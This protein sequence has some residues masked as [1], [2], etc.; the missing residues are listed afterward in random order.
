MESGKG[1]ER[2]KDYNRML[3]ISTSQAPLE[4]VEELVVW[5]DG[6]DCEDL[7]GFE[8][9]GG[10]EGYQTKFTVRSHQNSYT[11]SV[12]IK[13]NG[14]GISDEKKDKIMRL[15]YTTPK[16]TESTGLR[17]TI[18]NDIV[19]AHGSRLSFQETGIT[20]TTFG[21]ELWAS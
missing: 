4:G 19:K 16:G 20:R 10:I 8:N 14:P 7:H 5:E 21:I 2:D 12:E 1:R 18:I 3:A 11:I 6:D 9:L 13:D 15:F 17:L